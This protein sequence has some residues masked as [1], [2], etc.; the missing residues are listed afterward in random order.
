M[1]A[2]TIHR[3]LEVDPKRGG[4]KRGVEEPLE[5]DLLVI[6]ETSMVDVSLMASAVKALPDRAGLILVGDVDQLPSVWPGPVLADVLE[7]GAV[8]VSRL[9]DVFRPASQRHNRPAAPLPL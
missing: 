2:K 6:D 9:P 5:C 1:E 8:P 3:L 4:F 7:S